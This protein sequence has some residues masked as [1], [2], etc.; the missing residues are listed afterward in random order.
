MIKRTKVVFDYLV[1]K[2]INCEISDT[3]S[4]DQDGKISL[5]GLPIEIDIGPS[6][7]NLVY[8]SKS[9]FCYPYSGNNIIELYHKIKQVRKLIK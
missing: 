7:F 5:L 8:V 3:G 2:N 1:G 6:Y 9:G 4:F